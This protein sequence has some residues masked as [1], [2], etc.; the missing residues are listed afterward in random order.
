MILNQDL[1]LSPKVKSAV[2][3]S[4]AEFFISVVSFWEM[5]IKISIGKL[6]LKTTLQ[7]IIQS[8]IALGG[9]TILPIFV[10]HVVG[11]DSLPFHHRDPFDRLF[12]TQ[13][14]YEGMAIVSGDSAF[15]RYGVERIW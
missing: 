10:E 4:K 7:E 11:L 14:K 8:S 1:A 5:A 15:D 2:I 12:L 9:V 6:Q 3:N 13:A